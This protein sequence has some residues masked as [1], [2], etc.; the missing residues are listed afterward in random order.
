M[1]SR[2]KATAPGLSARERIE[3]AFWQLLEEMPYEQISIKGLAARAGVNHKTIY[4]YYENIDALARHLFEKIIST[5]FSETNPL[6]AVLSGRQ[7]QYWETHLQSVGVKRALLFS[8]SDSPLLNNILKEHIQRNWL[9]SVGITEQELTEVE[10]MELD[11]IFSGMMSLLDGDFSA[12]SIARFL[13]I[14]DR[15]LG[16]AVLAT[17][18][19]LGEKARA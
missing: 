5:H 15:A 14:S 18:T 19:A 9:S 17:F 10:R 11:F 7:E 1:M 12:E 6:T 8:R 3:E 4:Y 2:P 13:R 16:K